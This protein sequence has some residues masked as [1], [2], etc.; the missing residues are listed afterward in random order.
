[1]NYYSLRFPS[2]S[3]KICEYFKMK[4]DQEYIIIQYKDDFAKYLDILLPKGNYK[5]EIQFFN[6]H[7][8]IINKMF[9]R[10]TTYKITFH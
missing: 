4:Y 5:E 2:P 10:V 3:R 7:P 6:T 1:M 8:Y 9:L